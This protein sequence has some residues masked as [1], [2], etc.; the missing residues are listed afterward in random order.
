VVASS[1]RYGAHQTELIL[2]ACWADLV[3]QYES[4]YSHYF[5]VYVLRRVCCGMLLVKNTLCI[6]S[7]LLFCTH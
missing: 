6:V 4:I 3:A 5:L 7:R 2:G 1:V